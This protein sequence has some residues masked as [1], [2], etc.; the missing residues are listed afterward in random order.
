MISGDN[1]DEPSFRCGICRQMFMI[2]VITLRTGGR[3]CFVAPA[4][5]KETEKE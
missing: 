2:Y 1:R 3:K 4:S 5:S